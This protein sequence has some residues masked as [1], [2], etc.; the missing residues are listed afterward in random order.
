MYIMT[1]TPITAIEL[2]IGRGEEVDRESRSA[3]MAV[4]APVRRD[5]GRMILCDDVLNIPLA[6]CGATIPANP[7]GPQNAVTAAVVKQQL[8][9]DVNL[10]LCTGAPAMVAK[11]SPK[12]IISKPFELRIARMYPKTR[13]LANMAISFHPLL[14]KLPADQL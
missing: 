11:S 9:I 13:T 4:M 5:A 8:M 6:M 12:R 1:G 7:I 14:E 3:A 10:I 2:A